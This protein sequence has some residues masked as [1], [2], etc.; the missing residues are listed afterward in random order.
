MQGIRAI[1]D[2]YGILMHVDEVM[3]GF[4]RTGKLFGFQHYPGVMPDI[5]TAAKGISG[6]AVPLSMT[7]CSQEIMQF[8]DDKPL[9][10]GSTYQAHPV[11]KL[12]S[13]RRRKFYGT[14]HSDQ[15]VYR[16]C[17]AIT[18]EKEPEKLGLS[19]WTIPGGKFVK[20]KVLDYA[21]RVEIIGE[22]FESMAQEYDLDPN[23]PSIEFYRSQREVILLLPIL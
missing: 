2:K 3:V 4:G 20:E 16:A 6:A 7:A 18:D 17:T 14:Y 19:T 22:T 10:W 13:L 9:G 12:P 5:V 8:F 23:R 21:N 15:E 11:V 1:C